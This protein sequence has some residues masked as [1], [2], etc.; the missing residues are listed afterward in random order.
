MQSLALGFLR[1]TLI[2]E[3]GWIL[4]GHYRF[5]SPWSELLYPTLVSVGFTVIAVAPRKARWIAAPLRIFIGLAFVGAVCDR[6]GL[7]GKPGTP[8]VSWGDFK[9][10]VAYT[11]QVNSFLP[12]AVIRGLAVIE[13]FIEGGLGAAMILGVGV[14]KVSAAS[15][16]LLCCFGLAMT[17]SLGFDS[18]FPFAVFVLTAGAAVLAT[19]D[20]SSWWSVDAL[21]LRLRR[22]STSET[23][24]ALPR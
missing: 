14:R 15:A 21:F 2:V 17:I 4:L 3:F 7:F 8:G 13:S 20:S 16:T 1:I 5:N 11:A 24:T 19:L 23:P 6:L 22:G 12:A 9:N 18:Q 10:F